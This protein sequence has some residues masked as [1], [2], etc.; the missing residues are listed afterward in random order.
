MT[1]LENESEGWMDRAKLSPSFRKKAF[2][3]R[4]QILGGILVVTLA[5]LSIAINDLHS[6]WMH[7]T[8][9]RRIEAVN[10][11]VN[12]LINAAKQYAL[13]RGRISVLLRDVE[14]PTT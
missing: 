7:F 5:L 12:D 6:A 2:G 10:G 3:I 9:S 13:E 11:Y 1:D 8:D 4:G 14:P